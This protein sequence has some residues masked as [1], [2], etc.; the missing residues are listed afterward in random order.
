VGIEFSTPK[1][2]TM[3]RR[4]RRI[5]KSVV[6]GL[7]VAAVAAPPALCQGQGPDDRSL[8]RGSSEQIVSP[9]DR[10]LYRGTSPQP[11]ARIVSPDDRSFVRST[12]VPSEPAPVTVTASAPSD[13]FQWADA[14]LGAAL[15]MAFV[16]V[17]GAAALAIR[18]QRRRIAAY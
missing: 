1:E 2:A 16:F 7:A 6:L 8:Y 11:V 14:G 9:D 10:S 12:Q 5:I 13:D 18:Y 3:Y 4:K 15:T 17:L